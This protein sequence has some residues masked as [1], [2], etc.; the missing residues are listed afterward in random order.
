MLYEN[1]KGKRAGNQS[2][3]LDQAVALTL[4]VRTFSVWTHCWGRKEKGSKMMGF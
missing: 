1:L 4:T 3:H 2:E